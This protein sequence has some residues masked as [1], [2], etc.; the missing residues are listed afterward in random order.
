MECIFCKNKY[1]TKKYLE[2]HLNGHWIFKNLFGLSFND[3]NSTKKYCDILEN[4]NKALKIDIKIC[5]S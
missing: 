3:I 2:Q 5:K 1:T 4:E